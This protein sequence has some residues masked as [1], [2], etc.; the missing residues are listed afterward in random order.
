[1]NYS[2]IEAASLNVL[3]IKNIPSISAEPAEHLL[4]TI[5]I[6]AITKL[7]NTQTRSKRSAGSTPLITKIIINPDLSSAP[8]E[9]KSQSAYAYI[10]RR[11][12]YF[13]L[14]LF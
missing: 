7:I 6:T 1:M 12:L 5:I 3:N 2:I 13:I 9:R 14:S 8:S 11:E 4:N 10:T